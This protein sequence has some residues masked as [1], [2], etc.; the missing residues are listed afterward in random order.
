[1]NTEN[2]GNGDT[3]QIKMRVAIDESIIKKTTAQINKFLVDNQDKIAE[4]FSEDQIIDINFKVRY[5]IEKELL[6][7]PISINFVTERVKESVEL[8]IDFDQLQLFPEE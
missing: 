5:K 6:K 1:M 4:V 2:N 3:N 7:I 8:S